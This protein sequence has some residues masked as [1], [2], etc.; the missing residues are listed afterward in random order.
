MSEKTKA[1]SRL[2]EN[3]SAARVTLDQL[4]AQP[5]ELVGGEAVARQLASVQRALT[6]V[7]SALHVL[8]PEAR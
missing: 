3:L 2:T 6:E 8:H 1:L 7:R 5:S 4:A